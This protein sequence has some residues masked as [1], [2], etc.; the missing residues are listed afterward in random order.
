MGLFAC[1]VH[2]SL[3]DT[4]SKRQNNW[5]FVHV[6]LFKCPHSGHPIG[7]AF[8]SHQK[9][10]EVIDAHHFDLRCECGW[11]GS[12]LGITR[13]KAWAENWNQ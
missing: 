13:V 6:V 2:P 8:L 5:T 3:M 11:T 9:N 7:G 10:L 4:A 1:K 12:L